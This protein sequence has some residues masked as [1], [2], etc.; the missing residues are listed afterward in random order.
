MEKKQNNSGINILEVLIL[1]GLIPITTNIARAIMIVLAIGY[2]LLELCV[3]IY[4]SKN[5]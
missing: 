2:L 5:K 1:I 4:N 3:S